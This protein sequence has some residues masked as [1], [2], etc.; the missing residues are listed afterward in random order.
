[1][2]A[3][4]VRRLSSAPI[5]G[6]AR[7]LRRAMAMVTF[8]VAALTL[9]FGSPAPAAASGAT[10]RARRCRPFEFLAIS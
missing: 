8:A 4:L 3:S 7:I 9:A 5:W 1:M 2:K 6:R 10:G